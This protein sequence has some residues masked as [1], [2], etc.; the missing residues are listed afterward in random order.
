MAGLIKGQDIEISSVDFTDE[1]AKL[2]FTEQ[3]DLFTRIIRK[4]Y[5]NKDALLVGRSFGAWILINALMKIDD[6]YPG[7]VILIASVLGQGGQGNLQF[8]APR[9]WKFWEEAE[10]RKDSPASRLVLIHAVDDDQCPYKHAERLSK[11]W[12]IELVSFQSGGHG[13]GART[14]RM[15]VTEAV[16]RLWRLAE[17]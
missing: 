11:L 9:G 14:R 16:E 15:Q 1:F 5:W 13:L 12:D 17:D 4:D 7:T 8:I 3:M 10:A 6:T 2:L